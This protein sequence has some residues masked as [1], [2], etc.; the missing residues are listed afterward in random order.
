ML[1]LRTSILLVPILKLHKQSVLCRPAILQT[2]KLVT[3]HSQGCDKVLKCNAHHA[4]IGARVWMAMVY[5]QF[6][7]V[8]LVILDRRGT[9]VGDCSLQSRILAW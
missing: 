4:E 1:P 7:Q 3:A 6:Y 8:H 2:N 9:M 5:G